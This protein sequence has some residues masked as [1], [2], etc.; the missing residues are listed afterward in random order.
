V[1]KFTVLHINKFHHVIGGSELVYFGTADILEKHGHSSI[2]FSMQHTE[3]LPC[4]TSEYFVPY[5]DLD[6]KEGGVINYIKASMD[7]LYSFK[8]KRF[9][10][11]LL[12]RYPVD[13]AH[14]HNIQRQMSP[15]ILHELKKRK[16][17]VVM[18]L[19]EYKMI[20]PSFNLLNHGKLCD[21][22][23]G[24]KYFNAIKLR[25]I[26]DSL[27]RCGLAA[28]EMYLHHKILDIYKNVDI[29][30]SP[31]QFLKKKQ[32]E[33]G[34]KKETVHLPNCVD[35]DK[36][37]KFTAL[38][39]EGMKKYCI[40]YLG[41][42]VHEK[43][44][45]TFIEALRMLIHDHK[46]EDVEIK[47]IGDGPIRNDLQ[48]MVKIKGLNNNVRFLGF[49]RGDDRFFEAKD[50]TVIVLPSECNENYPLQA[51]ESFTLGIPVI[52]ARIGGIPEL[53]KD[54]ETGLTFEPGNPE[55]LC[56]KIEYMLNNPDIAAKMGERGR[57]F[58]EKNLNS[59]TYYIKLMEIYKRAI[60]KRPIRSKLQTCSCF[61]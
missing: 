3:N 30:I 19:H 13:I 39:K 28:V 11:K 43:G 5:I 6:N 54:N 59:E 31:S 56:S 61:L 60:N 45:F 40:V 52:G 51:I 9:L 7:V 32:E 8:A 44:L 25:C 16:I 20:C 10:S 24:G 21:A 36:F 29:F 27:P 18:T 41:R 33:M 49:I 55:D 53:V 17:P 58:V 4:D 35:I 50:A 1:K 34:F 15:S 2:F 12:D 14:I 57:L 37:D 46:K 23:S 22:C 42:L 48:E 47:V 26:K 38:K